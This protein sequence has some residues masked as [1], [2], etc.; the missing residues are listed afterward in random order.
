[1]PSQNGTVSCFPKKS[2]T[3]NILMLRLYQLH[4]IFSAT[5]YKDTH[6]QKIQ[7]EEEK[8]KQVVT[9]NGTQQE[10]KHQHHP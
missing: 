10:N 6:N 7:N 2:T 1:M 8:I 4:L 3:Y 5:R 9:T